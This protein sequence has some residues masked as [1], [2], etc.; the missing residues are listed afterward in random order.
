M[1]NR[2]MFD[3]ASLQG[4]ANQNVKTTISHTC[5]NGFHKKE[6]KTKC[7]QGYGEKRT[8]VH[9]WWEFDLVQAEV[10]KKT[11]NGTMV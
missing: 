2:H 8:L 10:Y 9:C 5:Q 3:I 11:K 6:H 1:A 4:N 7:W